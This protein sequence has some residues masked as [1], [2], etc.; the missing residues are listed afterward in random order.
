M[1]PDALFL[2]LSLAAPLCA[3]GAAGLFFWMLRHSEREAGVWALLVG[4]ALL[5]LVLLSFAFA[6]LEAH[7]RWGYDTTDV[8]NRS[9]VSKRWFERYWVRNGDGVRDNVEYPRARSPGVPRITFLGDSFTTA[10]GVRDVEDRFANRIRAERSEWQVHIFARNGFNTVEEIDEIRHI[11]AEGYEL[12]TVVLVYCHNDI[13]THIPEFQ[14]LYRKVDVPPDSLT[15]LLRHSYAADFYY[16]RWR[17][18]QIVLQSGVQHHELRSNAYTGQTWSAMAYNLELLA[19][20][21]WTR[22]GRF[23]VVTFPW[24]QMLLAGRGDLP[25]HATLDAFWRELGVPHLDLLPLFRRQPVRELVVNS[26]DTHPNERAHGLAS[27]AIL[28]FLE[29]DVLPLEPGRPADG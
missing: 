23:A 24:M 27:R 16:Q 4:N 14:Q 15:Y 20:D 29:E 21:V 13:D 11:T 12:D 26:R 19:N 7:Y 25:M 5:L 8:W 10:H 17:L 18:S 9:R 22:G 2:L 28:R 3:G 1:G 6:G